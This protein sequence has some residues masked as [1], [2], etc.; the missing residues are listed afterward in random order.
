MENKPHK[1]LNRLFEQGTNS[2]LFVVME[3]VTAALVDSVAVDLAVF[4]KKN[5]K[6][7]YKTC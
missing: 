3:E 5:K 1:I 2:F 7:I 6:C 4:L